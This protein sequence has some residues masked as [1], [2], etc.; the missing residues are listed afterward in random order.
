MALA[1]EILGVI[2][3]ITIRWIIYTTSC[4]CN[5]S[6]ILYHFSDIWRWRISWLIFAAR[7]YPIIFCRESYQRK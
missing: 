2:E 1:V 3:N 6:S 7:W 5:Y 4:R